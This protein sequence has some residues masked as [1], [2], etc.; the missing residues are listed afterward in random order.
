MTILER[1]ILELCSLALAYAD[2]K[3]FDDILAQLKA[4]LIEH[5]AAMKLQKKAA[6]GVR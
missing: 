1:R 4:A 5:E 6:S 2:K 3:A